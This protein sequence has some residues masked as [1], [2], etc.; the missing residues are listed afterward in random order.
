MPRRPRAMK[1]LH[2]FLK[3]TLLG[4]VLLMM[5]GDFPPRQKSGR[6]G[7]DVGGKTYKVH[8]DG[9]NQLPYLTGQSEKSPRRGFFYFDDDGDLVGVRVEN[10]KIVFMEQR[11]P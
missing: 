9:Y 6:L 3:A 5:F 11:V 10:W 4:G 1:Q 2:A 8:I 7:M